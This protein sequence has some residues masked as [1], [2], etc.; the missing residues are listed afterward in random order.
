M[1]TRMRTLVVVL[2]VAAAFPAAAGEPETLFRKGNEAYSNGRFMEAAGYYQEILRYGIAD[3]RVEYNL[4]NAAFKQGH[5]GEA[6]LHYRRA[7]LLDP[8]DDEIRGNLAFVESR[9]AD[10]VFRPES[11]GVVRWLERLQNRIGPDRQAL[12]SLAILWAV[13]LVL[14]AGLALP[15]RWKAWH[16][17]TTAG[18]LVAVL[19]LSCS[20][21]FTMSRLQPNRTAVVLAAEVEILTGP[22]ENNATLVVAHE[23]L[24]LAIRSIRNDWIQV[25][26]PDGLTGWVP[27]EAV[28][29]V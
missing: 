22:G 20:W 5:L 13:V 19:A 9:R 10:R 11:A 12:G 26:L 27:R 24:D 16:G 29:I 1:R 8:T 21:W 2:L 17:W 14:A 18:L 3:P 6:I 15:G 23:G 25:T 28:A 7:A 4:G